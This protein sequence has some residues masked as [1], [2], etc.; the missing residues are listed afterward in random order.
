MMKHRLQ[1]H[2][3]YG[4]IAS[5]GEFVERGE[6]LGLSVNEKEIVR[7][8]EAGRVRLSL[9]SNTRTPRLLVDIVSEAA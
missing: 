8:P 7:A 5:E 2:P 3:I 4:A 9:Q 1:L 6:I